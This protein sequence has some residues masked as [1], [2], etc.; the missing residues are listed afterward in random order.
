MKTTCALLVVISMPSLAAFSDPDKAARELCEMEWRITDRS[1]SSNENTQQIVEEEMRQ[2]KENS[3]LLS[4]YSIDEQDFKKV[5]VEGAD[6]FRKMVV[7]MDTPYPGARDFFRQRMMP[8]C[9]KNV[10]ENLNKNS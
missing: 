10:L 4:D 9:I 2:F 6:G 3:H 5:S 1:A 8:L 7:K